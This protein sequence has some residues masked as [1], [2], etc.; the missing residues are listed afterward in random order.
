MTMQSCLSSWGN[1]MVV[2]T[3]RWREHHGTNVVI[4][5][6][7]ALLLHAC[8]QKL[9]NSFKQEPLTEWFADLSLV[10]HCL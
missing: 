4:I 8:S 6:L 1:C 3:H 10:P 7:P 2:R 9:G 5:F